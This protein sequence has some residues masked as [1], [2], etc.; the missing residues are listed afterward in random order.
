MKLETREKVTDHGLR[1]LN[2][3]DDVGA[4]VALVLAFV[5]RSLDDPCDDPCY[6]VVCTAPREAGD[7]DR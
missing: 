3:D 7:N 4:N 1:G 6:G 5:I 2:A